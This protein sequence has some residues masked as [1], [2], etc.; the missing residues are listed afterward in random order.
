VRDDP[1]AMRTPEAGRARAA[2]IARIDSV[3]QAFAVAR[4]NFTAADS[5]FT[6]LAASVRRRST[7]PPATDSLLK[8]MQT[9][10]NQLR[11]RFAGSYGTP[12]GQIF[13]LLGGL[14]STSNAPTEAEERTL[15]FAASDIADAI[16]RLRDFTDLHL[17]RLRGANAAPL[18][19]SAPA[20][21]P[22]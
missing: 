11:G 10:A 19:G 15:R 14:E 16:K 20:P 9:E 7:I 1:R 6:R 4:R 17:V 2:T 18:V 5:E 21:V 13:D 3:V 12:I 8:A 22:H